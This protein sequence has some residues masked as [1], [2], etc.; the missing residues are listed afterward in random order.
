MRDLKR[1]FKST[2][3]GATEYTRLW[4]K[5]V[6][7]FIFYFL[8]TMNISSNLKPAHCIYSVIE[9]INWPF[10]ALDAQLKIRP[11]FMT[12][13]SLFA[14]ILFLSVHLPEHSSFKS[15]LYKCNI[16]SLGQVINPLP[17]LRTHLSSRYCA[18]RGNKLYGNYSINYVE[19]I[20]FFSSALWALFLSRSLLSLPL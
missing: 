2:F 11:W 18:R 14:T 8:F 1:A 15:I 5:S 6:F 10:N 17:T 9:T 4:V 16:F 20:T 13:I 12:R 3:L 19:T 7:S